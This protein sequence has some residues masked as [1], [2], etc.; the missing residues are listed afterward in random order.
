MTLRWQITQP[1]HDDLL[2]VVQLI[3]RRG[4]L[5]AEHEA[6][7]GGPGSR[8]S[9]MRPNEVGIESHR[10]ELPETPNQYSLAV[11]LKRP[12]GEWLELTSWPER[13][14]PD[15]RRGPAQVIV[16]TIDAQ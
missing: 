11:S 1:V 9:T 6:P 5:V 8:T 7:L 2:A 3:D 14:A 4:T 10:M 15:L 16:D 13:L 12:T